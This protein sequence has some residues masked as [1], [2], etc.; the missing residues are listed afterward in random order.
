MMSNS[1]KT[2][3]EISQNRKVDDFLSID[4]ETLINIST[5]LLNKMLRGYPKDFVQVVKFKRRTLK[6]RGYAIRAR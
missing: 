5:K 2:G 6:N 4:D 1:P 3:L